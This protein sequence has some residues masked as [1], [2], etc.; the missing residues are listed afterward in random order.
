MWNFLSL[1]RLWEIPKTVTCWYENVFTNRSDLF[2]L[3]NIDTSKVNQEKME[4]MTH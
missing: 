4:N 2:F 1:I 3:K